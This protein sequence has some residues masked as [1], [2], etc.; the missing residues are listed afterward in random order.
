ML[1]NY[2]NAARGV[3]PPDL[4]LKNGRVVNTFSCETEEADVAIYRDMIVGLWKYNGP[5]MLDMGGDLAIWMVTLNPARYFRL[6]R[7]GAIAPG[8]HADILRISSVNPIRIKAVFKKITDKGLIDV[9]RFQP[10]GLFV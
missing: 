2:I 10:V 1:K 8:F 7:S 5:K 4:V 9:A 6:T 3:I